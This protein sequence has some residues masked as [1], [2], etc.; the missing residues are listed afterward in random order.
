MTAYNHKG[1]K[2]KPHKPDVIY[3]P[4]KEE[5]ENYLVLY[6]NKLLKKKHI[7]MKDVLE[8]YKER[9]QSGELIKFKHFCHLIPYLE[10]DTKKH[11]S[12]LIR[13]FT[14]IFWEFRD[15][16]VTDEE[17]VTLDCVGHK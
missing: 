5:L 10:R 16:P 9:I 7:R 11:P 6:I 1:I 12:I 4:R 17:P 13:T 3:R 14:P 15:I 2:L 8:R